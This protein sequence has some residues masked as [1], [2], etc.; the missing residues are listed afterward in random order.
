VTAM[1][2]SSTLNTTDNRSTYLLTY[3]LTAECE[4]LN[5]ELTSTLRD[6]DDRLVHAEHDRQQVRLLT[7]LLSYL[8]TYS[9]I[10]VV[11][12]VVLSLQ[13]HCM[14]A[15]TD[16]ST[17]NTTDNRSAYLLTY[18]LTQ[19]IRYLDADWLIAS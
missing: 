8:L 5:T 12:M 19:H 9:L 2:D 15:M 10:V 6:C 3:L 1:T 18:L 7:Y 11:D 17:L 14:T 13:V 4:Q 16:S